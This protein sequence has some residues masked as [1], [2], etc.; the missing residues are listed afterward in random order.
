MNRKPKGV[1]PV[2]RKPKN[3]LKTL[4]DPRYIPLKGKFDPMINRELKKRIFSS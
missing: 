4:I 2:S 1:R 3:L